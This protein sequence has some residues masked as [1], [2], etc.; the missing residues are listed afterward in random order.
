V[1]AYV[2]AHRKSV[3]HIEATQK[4]TAFVRHSALSLV[5]FATE[6]HLFHSFI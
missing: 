6:C 1:F 4:L 5:I 3:V 2:N